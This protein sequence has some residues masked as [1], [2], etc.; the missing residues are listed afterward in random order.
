MFKWFENVVSPFPSD[1]AQRP[2]EGLLAFMW[3]YT[4]PFRFLL[5]GLLCT[6][7]IIAGIEVYMF[8][9]IGEIIDWMQVS[10]PATFFT[11]HKTQLIIIAV[12]IVV[13]WPLLNFIDSALEHQGLMGNFAM[14]IRWRAH[15]Y[16]LRQSTN[17]FA[18]DFSGRIATKVMQ[19]ALSV[20][21]A[22]VSLNGL[23]V[24]VFVYFISALVIFVANDWRIAIPLI[25]WLAGYILVMKL[26]LP[27]LKEISELQSDAR[28]LMTGRVVDAYTNIQT[29]KMFSTS[30]AEEDYARDSMREMLST[31]YQQMRLVTRLHTTLICLN[32]LL[33]C[34]TMGFGVWLWTQSVITTGTVAVAAA[35]TLRIQ[36]MSQWFIWELARLFEAIGTTQDGLNTIAQPTSVLDAPDASELQVTKGA[37]QFDRVSFHYGKEKGVISDFSLRIE[38]GERIG[39]VGQSG[40][41]KSTLVNLLLRLYDV[42]AG[43]ICIDGRNIARVTQESLRRQIAMVTQ[44]TSL[45]HRTIRENIAYGKYGATDAEIEC[46]ARLA[47]ADRF[48]QNLEDN[49]GN[50]GFDAKVGERGV[51]LSGGQRQRIAIARVILKN[52]PILVLDEATSALD[53]EVEAAIQEQLQTLMQGKTVLAI[54]HRLS[55]IAQMDRLIVVKAGQIVEQGTHRQLV[56][57]GGVYARLWE[58]QSGGFLGD[59]DPAELQRVV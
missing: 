29:V 4:K 47:R 12:L 53:S 21:D 55:T 31:V 17:F 30:N 48:I 50:R 52:A 45:L 54:A 44:D 3:H 25:V 13:L 19:T 36:S 42:E 22:I 23:V 6:S 33:I 7:A 8:N 49:E 41:G 59:Q 5:I 14:Q 28:S 57:A 37:I 56:D 16:L 35:L 32:A 34:G 26:F 38:P 51:K 18:N 15:R 20:R 43:R 27:K 11:T 9:V 1:R 46:A 2:P 40:A 39:L 10:D 58:H 24:Y